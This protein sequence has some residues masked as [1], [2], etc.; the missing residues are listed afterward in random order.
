MTMRTSEN[1]AIVQERALPIQ[2][3]AATIAPSTVD[4]EARTVELVW[5]TGARVMRVS[6][7]RGSYEEELSLDRGA[8]RMDRLD[9]GGTPLL[10][11][12]GQYDLDDVIGVI[13]KAWI[14][15]GEGRAL[16]RFS[17]REAV[18]SIWQDVR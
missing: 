9:S 11:T 5:T 14:S 13:E 17:T 15:E 18:D 8:V 12:H 4:E 3:R 16:A 2:V 1:P 10:N 7:F 6:W